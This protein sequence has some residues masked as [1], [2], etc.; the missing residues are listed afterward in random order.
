MLHKLI[1]TSYYY[2]CV[3]GAGITTTGTY[4]L[5]SCMLLDKETAAQSLEWHI[6]GM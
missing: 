1:I 5:I 3:G 2:A 4:A 6:D